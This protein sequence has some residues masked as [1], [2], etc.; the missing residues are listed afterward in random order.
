MVCNIWTFCL[1]G[2][3]M[4]PGKQREGQLWINAQ[5]L[6]TCRHPDCRRRLAAYKTCQSKIK[7]IERAERLAAQWRRKKKSGQRPANEAPA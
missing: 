7:Y 4:E 3:P 5:H 1:G 6:V 2:V